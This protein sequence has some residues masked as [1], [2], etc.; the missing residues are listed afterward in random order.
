MEDNRTHAHDGA[1]T[2]D[3]KIWGTTIHALFENFAFRRAVI[4]DLRRAKGLTPRSDATDVWN[5]DQE[6]NKLAELVR[7]HLDLDA[8]GALLRK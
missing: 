5:L 6:Y 7:A 3:G 1:R 8:V 4:D 2:A